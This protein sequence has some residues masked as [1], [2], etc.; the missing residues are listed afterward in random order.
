MGSE[1][2]TPFPDVFVDLLDLTIGLCLE[3]D[4]QVMPALGILGEALLNLPFS[5]ALF[6]ICLGVF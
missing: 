6:G 5:K 4:P 2:W 3:S 1:V